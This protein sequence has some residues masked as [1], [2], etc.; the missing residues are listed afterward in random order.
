[1]QQLLVTVA[2]E[3]SEPHVP[4]GLPASSCLLPGDAALTIGTL[5]KRRW[6]MAGFDLCVVLGPGQ[7]VTKSACPA[8]SG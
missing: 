6:E 8:A 5:C 7:G 1:M 4:G 3:H 2:H